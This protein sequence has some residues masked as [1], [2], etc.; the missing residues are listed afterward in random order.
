M[1]HG[2]EHGAVQKLKGYLEILAALSV[3]ALCAVAVWLGISQRLSSAASVAPANAAAARGPDAL[4]NRT[5][6]L[7]GAATIGERGARVAVVEYSDFHC[8][9]CSKFAETIW[10]ELASEYVQSGRALWAFK[11]FPLETAHP[12]AFRAAE[13]SGCALQQGRFW[14]MHDRLFTSPAAPT[15]DLLLEHASVLKLDLPRFTQCMKGEAAPQVW[16]DIETGKQL[17]VAGTPTFLLGTVQED[18]QVFVRKRITGAIPAAHFKAVLDAFLKE[19][20][21]AKTALTRKP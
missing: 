14:E 8:Q 6:S 4:L 7:A 21:P 20:E 12:H 13:A 10:P 11:H 19:V 1:S 9:F 15:D 18:G 3:I 2:V 17:G 16:Q 5:L